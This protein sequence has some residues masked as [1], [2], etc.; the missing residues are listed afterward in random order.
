MKNI[1]MI[2]FAAFLVVCSTTNAEVSKTQQDK[3]SIIE[4]APGDFKPTFTKETVIKLNEIVSRS[5]DVI[6]EY[7]AIIQTVQSSGLKQKTSSNKDTKSKQL[8]SEIAQIN[9]LSVRSKGIL[10][11]MHTAEN[12]L[13]TSGE[14]YNVVIFAGMMGFVKDVEREISAQSQKLADSLQQKAS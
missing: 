11:E 7:D 6:N 10:A 2:I 5:L 13:K 9:S 4:L 8:T 12:Q 14:E 3:K 1:L